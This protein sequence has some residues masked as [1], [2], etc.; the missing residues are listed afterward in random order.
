LAKLAEGAMSIAI[1][2]SNPISFILLPSFLL[3]YCPSPGTAGSCIL[4][5]FFVPPSFP[6]FIPFITTPLDPAAV[7]IGVS[8]IVGVTGS[9]RRRWRRII[10]RLGRCRGGE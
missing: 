8:I 6:L 5:P 4:I 3:S 7:A 1:K 2:N 10:D 9:S